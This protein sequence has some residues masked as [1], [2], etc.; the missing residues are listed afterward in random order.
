[1]EKQLL[2]D[3]YRKMV[4]IRKFEEKGIELYSQNL[5]RGSLHLYIGE[6]AIA[7]GV[8]QALRRDDYVT[9]YHRGHGHTVAKGGDM[10]RMF[11]E[12]LGKETGYCKGRGGSMHI[13]D[14]EIGM[15]GANGIVGG[16][17]PIAVGAGLSAK[18]QGSDRVT[19]CF[20]GDGASN[21]GSF[22]E[23]IN[24][25]AVWG[26]PVIFVCENNQYGETN[27]HVEACAVENVGDRACAYG[28]PGV[29]VDGN[30]ALAVYEAAT[31]AVERARSGGGPTLIEGKT[32][33][34][35]GHFYG[36]SSGYRTKEEIEEW[37]LKDPVTTFRARVISTGGLP[38]E[39]FDRI[40]AEVQQ[41]VDRA[42]EFA[43]SSPEPNPEE[44]MEYIYV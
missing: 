8:C 19:V 31:A 26:L 29:V 1:M 24:L 39:E 16:G 36:E 17:I 37:R 11:A 13:A 42:A 27:P 25:A 14:F 23:A 33:R 34:W 43:V 4:S 22:H 12:M 10:G 20:F 18:L 6:E 40:D 44:A 15:L 30:D 9:S 7:A 2:L 21:E 41:A 35:Y 5:M 38:E 3:L 32:Y 28:I